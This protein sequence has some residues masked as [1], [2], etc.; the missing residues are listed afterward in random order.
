MAE[1]QILDFILARF[2]PNLVPTN[3]FCEFYLY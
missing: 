3:F 2:G 1:N